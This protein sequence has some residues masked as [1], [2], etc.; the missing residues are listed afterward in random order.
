MQSYVVTFHTHFGATLFRKR[1]LPRFPGLALAPVPRCLSASCGICAQFDAADVTG[2]D[3]CFDEFASE[4]E[5]DSLYRH[6]SG[7]YERLQ[8]R[9]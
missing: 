5:A 7:N 1:A 8:C 9:E 6:E 3:A 2:V 4:T